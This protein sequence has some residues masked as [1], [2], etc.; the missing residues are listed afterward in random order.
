MRLEI[1]LIM[2]ISNGSGVKSEQ[3]LKNSSSEYYFTT[4]TSGV[5]A[6]LILFIT[7]IGLSDFN[8]FTFKFLDILLKLLVINEGDPPSS[9]DCSNSVTSSVFSL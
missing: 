6:V 1:L 2:M 5:F 7:S 4:S 3:R 9:I 8:I